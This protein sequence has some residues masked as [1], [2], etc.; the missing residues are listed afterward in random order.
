[1]HQPFAA[2][3]PL[4]IALTARAYVRAIVALVRVAGKRKSLGQLIPECCGVAPDE[5]ERFVK[6]SGQFNRVDKL[7]QFQRRQNANVS[8]D[9]DAASRNSPAPRVALSRHAGI[10]PLG[11]AARA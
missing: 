6:R 1:M 11:R 3:L 7:G 9:R 10:I 8:H 5:R 2:V 4:R